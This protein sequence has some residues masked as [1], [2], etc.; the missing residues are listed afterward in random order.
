MRA[1]A[2]SGVHTSGRGVQLPRQR[3]ELL[4]ADSPQAGKP[5]DARQIEIAESVRKAMAD[6]AAR[7][8]L[9]RYL[10]ENYPAI[11]ESMRKGMHSSISSLLDQGVAMY[12]EAMDYTGGLI[13]K[14]Y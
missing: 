7:E 6:P 4:M 11:W 12:A 8:P 3:R 2:H 10:Q 9:T 14:S 5:T 1:S 13:M